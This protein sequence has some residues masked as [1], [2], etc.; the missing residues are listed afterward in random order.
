MGQALSGASAAEAAPRYDAFDATWLSRRH[1]ILHAATADDLK[2]SQDTPPVENFHLRSLLDQLQPPVLASTILAHGQLARWVDALPE[3]PDAPFTI[4]VLGGSTT[5]G[6]ECRQHIFGT[7]F[8]A[9]RLTADEPFQPPSTQLDFLTYSSTI[10]PACPWP[11]RMRALLGAVFP[12]VF[13]RNVS[14][15]NLAVGG[16]TLQTQ[17]QAL[18][19]YARR[20]PAGWSP[21]VIVAS[22]ATNENPS[23][24]DTAGFLGA[25][26]PDWRQERLRRE[27][28]ALVNDVTGRRRACF[29][30]RGRRAPLLIFFEDAGGEGHFGPAYLNRTTR[31]Q[32]PVAA[33][34]GLPLVNWNEAVKALTKDTKLAALWKTPKCALAART[35]R[36]RIAC[37]EAAA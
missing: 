31:V 21:N 9:R 6:Q 18:D 16:S 20:Q 33:A 22:T 36:M 12:D 11:A 27:T 30:R 37:G 17:R 24:P 15:V 35:A 29:R 4:V 10:D 3:S 25:W 7:D 8:R 2:R 13:G 26:L 19:A 1:A 28:E 34:A 32:L 23:L 5:E 14:M